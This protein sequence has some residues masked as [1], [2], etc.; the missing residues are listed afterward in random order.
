MRWGSP[1][2]TAWRASEPRERRDAGGRCIR[3]ILGFTA[4]SVSPYAAATFVVPAAF[5]L[6]W[7][8]YRYLLRPLV[9]RAKSRGMLE[10]DTILATFGLSFV[11]VGLI[12]YLSGRVLHVF[13]SRRALPVFGSPFGLNRLAASAAAV[14]SS[15]ACL[16]WGIHRTRP[17]MAIRAVAVDPTAAGLVAIDVH[18]CPHSPFA[19]RGSHRH[20]RHRAEHLPHHGRPIGVVFTMKRSSSSSWAAWATCAAPLSPR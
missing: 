3:R 18:G 2:G 19:R 8:I 15:A 16:Y 13:L 6:N 11:F 5:L 9:R 4:Q 14:T 20:R 10:V 1:C 17:G 7:L 12:C